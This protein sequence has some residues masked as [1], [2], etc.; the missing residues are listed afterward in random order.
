M[1]VSVCFTRKREKRTRVCVCRAMCHLPPARQPKDDGAKQC[2]LTHK[3]H[4]LRIST[5]S[6][7]WLAQPGRDAPGAGQRSRRDPWRICC[8]VW[9]ARG[10][11]RRLADRMGASGG[12]VCGLGRRECVVVWCAIAGGRGGSSRHGGMQLQLASLLSLPLTHLQVQRGHAG[13]VR[14]RPE[15][16]ALLAGDRDQQRLQHRAHGE[17]RAP[18][19]AAA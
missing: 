16:P 17:K 13:H 7:V 8:S 10:P 6:Y 15:G 11:M 3:T 12:H 18:P 5:P 2:A 1:H 14:A 4:T 9:Q 19:P